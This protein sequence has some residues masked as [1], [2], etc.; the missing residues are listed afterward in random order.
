MDDRKSRWVD[1]ATGLHVLNLVA[2]VCQHPRWYTLNGTFAE[3]VAFLHGCYFARPKQPGK[4]EGV[5]LADWDGFCAWLTEK[6]QVNPPGPGE[7]IRPS[8]Y[9]FERIFRECPDDEAALARLEDWWFEYQSS[10]SK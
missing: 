7:G 8:I 4:E 10:P 5:R 1:P 6:L 9:S 3:A 2:G